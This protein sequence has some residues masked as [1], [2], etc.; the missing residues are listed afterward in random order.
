MT[1]I[2]LVSSNYVKHYTLTELGC[3]CS[4]LNH[5][6]ASAQSKRTCS[7]YSHLIFLLKQVEIPRPLKVEEIFM[8]S[9][10]NM[11]VAARAQACGFN[12]VEIHGDILT[13]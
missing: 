9:L 11:A 2:C 10:K 5:A 1:T 12:G 13:Y 6:G 8:K 4:Q 7:Q 3:W